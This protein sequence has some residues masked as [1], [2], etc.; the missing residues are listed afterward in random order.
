MSSPGIDRP[1]VRITDFETWIG[2]VAK[3]ETRHVLNGR[4][5]H[6]G[7]IV[8]VSKTDNEITLKREDAGADEADDIVLPAGEI[9]EAKLVLTDDLIREA[10]R[11]DKALRQANEVNEDEIDQWS[12]QDN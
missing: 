8:G 2:H 6:R 4:K 10:L 9:A 12:S 5:R 7:I 1:L 11:R 3:L